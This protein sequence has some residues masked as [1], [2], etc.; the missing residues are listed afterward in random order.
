MKFV[1]V[2]GPQAVGKMTVGFELASITELK[3]FH[4]HMTLEML[5]PIFGFSAETWRLSSLFRFEIFEAVAKSD[6]QGL[7][8]TYVWAFDQQE[9]WDFVNETCR[10][11][12]SHGAEVYFVELAATLEERLERNKTPHRLEQK[13]S[14]RNLEHS[15][16]ELKASMDKYRLNSLD[17]EITSEHYL[18]I[19][20]SN[21]SPSEVA[22][23]IKDE[24]KL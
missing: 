8:F 18:R 2:F 10:I 17:G 9:D 12:E 19:D 7:I 1:L 20:N 13:P 24:F 5:N 6:M 4:N 3:L 14:K 21:S 22:Q 16:N 11:F 23:L 15:E